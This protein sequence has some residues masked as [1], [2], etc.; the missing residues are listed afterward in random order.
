M[1]KWTQLKWVKRG[2]PLLLL[3]V[4]LGAGAFAFT[5]SN[6]FGSS[7][8]GA[9]GAGSDTISGYTIGAP[10]Y[11]LLGSN[12]N[13]IASFAFTMSPVTASTAVKE[14][15]VANTFAPC[16]VGTITSGSATVT[17][18]YAGGSEPDIASASDLTV[19]GVN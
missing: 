16:S 11:T 19:V 2:V 13:K 8:G 15:V 7:A 12:A 10:S 3:A 5:A 17:C 1:D 18:T 6:T 9:A 14:G 4:A